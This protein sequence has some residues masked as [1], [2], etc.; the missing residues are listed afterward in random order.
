MLIS[1]LLEV[2]QHFIFRICD[3][4][5]GIADVSCLVPYFTF[6]RVS[7]QRNQISASKTYIKSGGGIIIEKRLESAFNFMFAKHQMT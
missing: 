3:V 5:C 1:R 6:D 2:R 7:S 4:Y